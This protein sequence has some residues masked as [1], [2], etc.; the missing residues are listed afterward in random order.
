MSRQGFRE[1]DLTEDWNRACDDLEQ[2][3]PLVLPHEDRTI[4]QAASALVAGTVPRPR[5]SLAAHRGLAW[6]GGLCA[7]AQAWRTL[8]GVVAEGGP[9]L[10]ALVLRHRRRRQPGSRPGGP[11]HA[12]VVFLGASLKPSQ[13]GSGMLGFAEALIV[14][15]PNLALVDW[16]TGTEVEEGLSQVAATY[17]V[18]RFS[19]LTTWYGDRVAR[20]RRVALITGPAANTRDFFSEL[21][22][23]EVAAPEALQAIVLPVDA[24]S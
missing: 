20:R 9:E 15:R 1:V 3:R 24:V 14:P 22:T 8:G 7:Y 23:H 17:T 13:S 2:S 5:G 18:T 19:V 11:S 4:H 16:P 12:G 21:K 10:G 6:G